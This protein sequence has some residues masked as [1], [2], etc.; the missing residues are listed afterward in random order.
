MTLSAALM[1]L[2]IS[3][4]FVKFG[5]PNREKKNEKSRTKTINLYKN[6]EKKLNKKP[7]QK[8]ETKRE[9]EKKFE[10]N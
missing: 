1:K 5:K 9:I 6:R 3:D 10:Q 2:L 4:I 8:C 7:A